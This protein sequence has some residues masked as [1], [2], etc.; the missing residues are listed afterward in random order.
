[1]EGKSRL[2]VVIGAIAMGAVSVGAF[3][4]WAY[5]SFAAFR[6][7]FPHAAWWAWIFGGP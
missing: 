6:E 1:M 2:R 7:K 3:G 4:M 5:L